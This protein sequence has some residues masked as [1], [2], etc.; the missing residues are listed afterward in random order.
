MADTGYQNYPFIFESKG[1]VAR[2]VDDKTPQGVFLDL[3]SLEEIAENAL[4][5]RLGTTII[6]KSG[7]VPQPLPGIVHSLN[8]L[9]GLNGAAFRYAGQGGNLY[10]RQALTPGPYSLISSTLSGQPWTAVQYAPDISSLPFVYI[11]DANGVIKDNGTLAAPQNANMLQPQYPVQAVAQQPYL[12]VLDNYPGPSSV[13]TYT[14]ISGG[15]I[16]PYVNTTLTSAVT[17]IGLRAVSVAA[18]T[19]VGLFQYLTINSGGGTQESVLVLE[20]T[21]T[22]FV[23]NFTQLHSAAETVTSKALSVTVPASTTAEVS[24]S[25]G[26]TPISTW[27]VTLNQEDYIGLYLYVS[28]PSQIQ[29]IIISFDCGNGTF[30]SDYF[31]RTIGQGPL[32]TLLDTNTDSSTSAADVVLS[33]SLGLFSPNEAGISQL[34]TG[35]TQWTPLLMQLS[36]FAGAGRADFNDPVFNWQNVNGYQIQ[37]VTNAN[38]SATVQFAAL[39]LFGGYGADSFAGVAYD[40]LFTFYNVND[41]TESNPSMVMTNVNPPLQTNW[42]LPRRQP[43]LL[44]IFHPVLDPQATHLRLYRRGG[45]LGDNYRRIDQVPVSGNTTAYQDIW[46]DLQIEQADTVSF[47]NDCPVTSTLPVPVNT[48]ITAAINTTNQV[49]NVYCN[50]MANISVSQQVD[51]GNVA[52]VNFE[53]VI[54]LTVAANYFTAFV[55]NTHATNETVA[56]T[57]SYA[58]PVTIIAEAFDQ[59]WYGGDLQ[60]PSYLYYS[61]KSNPVAVGSASYVIVTVPS[62][63]ITAI[64]GTR[65]NLFVSTLKKWWSIAPGSNQPGSSPTPYPTA[66]DHGCVGKLAWCLKDGM[67]YYLSQDGLRVFSGSEAP[68]ISQIIE[69]VFQNVG[70]TPI[71]IADP[72]QFATARAAWWNK[73]VFFSY[74]AM[75]GKRHRIILDTENKRFRNDDLD[76]QSL[77]LESD[78]NPNVLVFGD[79]NGFIHQDRQSIAYD[80]GVTAGAIA[81]LPITLTMQTPYSDQGAPTIQKNYN[82]LVLD[83]NTNGNN[84]IAELLFNDGESSITLGTIS[85]TQRSRINL[86]VNGGDGY[87]AYKASLLLTGSGTQRIFLFQAAIQAIPLAVTRQSYDTYWQDDGTAEGK[88]CKQ[89]YIDYNASAP[90]I[91]T[92]YYDESVLIPPFV[93]T[94]PLYNG[95]R[96]SFRQRLPAVKYRLRRMVMDSAGNDFQIWNESHFEVKPVCQGKGYEKIPLLSVEK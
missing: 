34:N 55:Q 48:F 76:C 88:L 75:D 10:R 61:A 50:Q 69:F 64:V 62:D 1:I 83:V 17:A 39:V 92:V 84:L 29:K 4:A 25:F 6:N 66:T 12:Q 87:Q 15:T 77:F 35:L 3:N 8:K 5:T 72:A 90:I 18:P 70:T 53:V 56:A 21:A 45:T 59:A 54:V 47:T 81:Q 30:Q 41:G 89:V 52:A 85:N 91:C 94:L 60:N 19:Q 9:G 24:K 80:E 63:G 74:I 23:A 78:V 73:F 51:L 33:E 86:N 14:G 96:N 36:D 49:V 67:I 28:D 16:T 32:Q 27:P 58:Q 26:G 31:Y 22:G 42:V 37:I 79:S 95:V 44:T 65:T 82:N 71:P 2:Y 68:Y 40:Y 7:T 46:E 38:S 57:A 13:Y 93:F 20:V 11:A 43:V